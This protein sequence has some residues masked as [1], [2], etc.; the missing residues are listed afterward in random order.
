M[1]Y[2]IDLIAEYLAVCPYYKPTK[3]TYGLVISFL[4]LF[5]YVFILPLILFILYNPPIF[6]LLFMF[7]SCYY[8]AEVTRYYEEYYN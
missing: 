7:L 2:F 6:I 1:F 3:L 4:I 5:T 8:L